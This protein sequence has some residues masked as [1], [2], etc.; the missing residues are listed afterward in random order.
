[1]ISS[2]MSEYLSVKN[3]SKSFKLSRKQQKIEKDNSKVRIAVNDIS[4][5]VNKGEIFGLLGTNGAGKTTMLRMISSLI[6]VDGGEI[7]IDGVSVGE[8]PELVRNK[9]G[10]LTSEMK[11]EGFFTPNYLYDF[12]SKIYGVD[13]E[14]AGK[15]KKILYENFGIDKFAE[16]KIADL[17]TGMKQKN[18]L[19]LA[20]VH[21]PELII[22]D[23][24]TNG[25][26]VITAKIVTDFLLDMKKKGKTIILSTHIFS[27][28]EKLCDRVAIISNGKIVEQA[29]V[30]EI[31]KTNSME[32][33][34]FE[35]YNRK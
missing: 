24:P 30:S 13:C 3:V 17:S 12:Y 22:F 20:L 8:S 29:N 25:L 34:F 4:F 18:A 27:I 35:I 1:M 28:V 19:V 7:I 2:I 10:F 21:D 33:Y 14:T 5:Y 31:I 9:I 15:R 11:Q 6:S 26:D 23:E 32:E 16:V